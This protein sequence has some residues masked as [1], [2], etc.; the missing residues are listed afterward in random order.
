LDQS[1]LVVELDQIEQRARESGCVSLGLEDEYFD[2]VLCT[3]L[4]RIARPASL[5]AEM[6][7]VLKRG[8]QIW[9]QAPLN[10][11]HRSETN[12]THPIYWQFTPKGFQVLCERFDEIRCSVRRTAISARQEDSFFYGMKPEICLEKPEEQMRPVLPPPPL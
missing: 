7:R 4:D 6:R 5:I 3:G 10:R 8:G 2:K 9:V 1:W 12:D 11:A